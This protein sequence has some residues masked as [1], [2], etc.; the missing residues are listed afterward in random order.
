MGAAVTVYYD[1]N[2]PAR[3]VVTPRILDRTSRLVAGISLVLVA[4]GCVIWAATQF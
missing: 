1:P 2:D 3:A 4:V